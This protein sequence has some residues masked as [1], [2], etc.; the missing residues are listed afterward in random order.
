MDRTLLAA[1]LARTVTAVDRFI[2]ASRTTL[3]EDDRKLAEGIV[4]LAVAAAQRLLDLPDP[5]PKTAQTLLDRL[6]GWSALGALAAEQRAALRLS[7]TLRSGKLDEVLQQI[8]ATLAK[9]RPQDTHAAQ[10]I[11]RVADPLEKQSERSLQAGDPLTAR[12]VDD[13]LLKVYNFLLDAARLSTDPAF[14]NQEIA[15]RRRLAPL[16]LRLG[17]TADAVS[18]YEFLRE[19][20]PQ[21]K[22]GDIL[23]GLG[24]AYE[25]LGRSEMAIDL[26]R[27]LATGLKQDT[28]DWFEAR[29][30]LIRSYWEAGQQDHARKL[31][32]Y[33]RLQYPQGAP[34]RWKTP[35]EEL[36]RQME[37]P[38]GTRR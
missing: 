26:W 2:E 17:R 1:H 27:L 21:E 7:L 28:D 4:T 33:F 11:I 22:A 32:E 10:A 8:D 19:K 23:R 25:K 12:R 20:V 3:S 34:G 6:E 16:L 31:M 24:L 38:A 5:H 37:L 35:F 29:W 36:Y 9:T 14:Q 18:H 15:I 13:R 30:H